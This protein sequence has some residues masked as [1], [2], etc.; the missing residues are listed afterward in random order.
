M[1]GSGWFMGMVGV[2]FGEFIGIV[3][4]GLGWFMGIVGGWIIQMAAKP[5]S[6]WFNLSQLFT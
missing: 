4:V 2:E 5:S 6:V 1:V 3:G